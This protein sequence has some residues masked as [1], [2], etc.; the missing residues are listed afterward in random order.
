MMMIA[1]ATHIQWPSV[2]VVVVVVVEFSLGR[3]SVVVVTVMVVL[4]ELA[5]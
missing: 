2:V 3:L 1:F 4:M 5:K